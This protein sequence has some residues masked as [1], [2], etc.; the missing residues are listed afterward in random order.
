MALQPLHPD[1]G[2]FLASGPKRMIIGG[3][4]VAAHAGQTFIAYN[5][6]DGEPLCEVYAGDAQDVDRAVQAARTALNEE[7]ATMAPS[8]RERIMRRWA[9]LIEANNDHLAQLETLENGKPINH[10]GQIDAFVAAD[11]VYHFAGWPSKIEGETHPVSIPG[12]FV[13]TL[14][15]P[16]GVVGIIIPWNYPL[17]H[18]MQKA[19]PALACGNAV[20]LKPAKQASL[21]AVKLGELAL[22]AGFPP[23]AFNV[24]TGSGAVIGKAM[25]SHPQIDKIAITGSTEVGQS[26]IRNSTVNIKRLAL[27]LGSKAPNCV[28]DDADL[29]KAIPGS[30]MAAFG[31]TGQSC[32]AGSR[33][34]VQAAVYDAVL[35]GLVKLAAEART[36]HAMDPDTTFGPI[37]DSRQYETIMDYIARGKADGGTLLCGG[38]RLTGDHLPDGGYYLPPTIFTGLPLDHPVSREEIFGPVLPVFKFETEAE[39]IA[40]AND[41]IYGLAAGVWTRDVAR[42]HRLAAAIK[43]GVVWVNTYNLFDSGTPFGGFK[44]SGYGR[45]NSQ[46]AIDAFSEIKA[47]WIDLG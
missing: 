32:V 47:V 46:Y 10:T 45:D 11:E 7:W 13:Y 3:E 25:S 38:E 43:A 2:A 37:I 26:V 39:L 24:I 1:T 34:Y 16:V 22:E 18:A 9:D 15:E 33:L 27:E 36:G 4:Q 30:F 17:I 6:S 8:Q 23:G 35:D 28:F 21:A 42:A 14:R 29:D 5:P 41:S 31:N 19:A 12:K 20:I 44:Q 40:Q